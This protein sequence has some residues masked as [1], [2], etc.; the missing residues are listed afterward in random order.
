MLAHA[1]RAG[2][3]TFLELVVVVAL[4]T[5]ITAAI[6]PLYGASM[7]AMKRRAARGDLVATIQYLQELSIRQ[8]RELRLHLDKDTGNYWATGWVAGIDEDATY[9]PLAD[10]AL[11]E[12]RQLPDSLQFGRVT[13]RRDRGGSYYITFYPNG[14]SDA[15]RIQLNGRKG[16]EKDIEIEITGA[17]GEI[18]VT[19]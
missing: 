12:T 4:L 11:G 17:L 13:A 14:A 8:S 16:D 6:V 5:I 9:M 2:G 10:T 3:F 1:R 15:A 18:L 7:G 19:P